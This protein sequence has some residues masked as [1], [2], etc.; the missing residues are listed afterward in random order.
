[1]ASTH[2]NLRD[3]ESWYFMKMDYFLFSAEKTTEDFKDSFVFQSLNYTVV[4]RRR[5][6]K[7]GY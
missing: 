1:M 7:I 2:V 5:R 4:F 3:Q 6:Y